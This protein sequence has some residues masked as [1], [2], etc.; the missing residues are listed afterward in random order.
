[1]YPVYCKSCERDGLELESMW[2]DEDQIEPDTGGPAVIEQ[3]TKIVTR[4]LNEKDEDARVRRA[5]GLTSDDPLPG[6]DDDTRL[7]L[8]R[9]LTP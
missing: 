4:P 9:N 6:V 2:Q 3:P 1:M 5:F 7:W 8:A